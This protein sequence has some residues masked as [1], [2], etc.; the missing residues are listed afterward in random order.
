M[1]LS[2]I[3]RP[4][5]ILGLIIELGFEHLIFSILYP[6]DR[7]DPIRYLEEWTSYANYVALLRDQIKELEK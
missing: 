3:F 5:R 2:N 4:F 1:R 7:T 6:V